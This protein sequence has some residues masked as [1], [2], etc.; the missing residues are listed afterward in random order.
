MLI[1]CWKVEIPTIGIEQ[2]CLVGILRTTDLAGRLIFTFPVLISQTGSRIEPAHAH[3][4]AQPGPLRAPADQPRFLTI[5]CAAPPGA[6]ARCA[7][8][9]RTSARN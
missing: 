1:L 7:A 6:V 2:K 3:N 8:W 9:I 4:A 5:A